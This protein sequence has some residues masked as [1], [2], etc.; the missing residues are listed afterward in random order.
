MVVFSSNSNIANA[1][2]QRLKLAPIKNPFVFPIDFPEAKVFALLA[3]QFGPPNG[4]LTA[5][6]GPGEASDAPFKWDYHF[7]IDGVSMHVIRS[8][9]GLELHCRE[10]EVTDA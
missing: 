1:H 5:Y 7:A 2:A 8:V 6:L 10:G 4:P 9:S 3:S